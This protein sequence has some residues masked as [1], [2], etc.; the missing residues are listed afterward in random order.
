MLLGN[1]YSGIDLKLTSALEVIAIDDA[2]CKEE[3]APP[4]LSDQG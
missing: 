1:V 2:R 4:G 3:I